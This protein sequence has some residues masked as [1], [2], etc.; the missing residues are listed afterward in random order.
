[1]GVAWLRIFTCVCRSNQI[2]FLPLASFPFVLGGLCCVVDVRLAS[3]LLPHPERRRCHRWSRHFSPHCQAYSG[4]EPAKAYGCCRRCYGCR[5]LPYH[6]PRVCGR[7]Q[8]CVDDGL[9]RF[10]QRRW[11]P[12]GCGAVRR[13]FC[14]FGE[15]SCYRLARQ[16]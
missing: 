6:Y 15:S 11:H 7:S 8:S 12:V 14:H 4:C 13:A 3:P 5:A 16:G 1:M 2:L 9:G 10:S